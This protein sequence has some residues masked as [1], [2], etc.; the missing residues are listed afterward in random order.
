MDYSQFQKTIWNHYQSHGR[1]DLPWRKNIT[2][3][4]I[5]VSE[6]MLQQT[7]V[8]RV[9]PFFKRWMRSFPSWK[10]LASSSTR[11]VLAHWKG[12]GYNSRG[13]RLHK[14][15]QIVTEEYHGR[16][17]YDTATLLSLPGIGPYTASAIRIFA[18]GKYDSCIETNIRRIFIH[19]FFKDKKS[20][21]DNQ[22][23]ELVE[24]TTPEKMPRTIDN[25]MNLPIIT[26]WYW[27]LMDYGAHLPKKIALNPNQKS[28]HYV[29]QST[30][31]GSKRQL[32]G[33]ILKVLLQHQ[34]LS[35]QKIH[36]ML[37][38]NYDHAT[39]DLVGEIMGELEK[40]GF[41]DKGGQLYRVKE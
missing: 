28:R 15:A 25:S 20:I 11:E 27:A 33:A 35:A 4:R 12:L 14:L 32:R 21:H 40:E 23:I 2:P 26:H 41:V 17:P 8:D 3:Y 31:K 10:K 37:A 36:A 19:H 18:Y 7:Q 29:K 5:A 39:Q 9:I 1:H 24:K 30:F 16:L 13:L 38:Q 34:S 6:I 22:I